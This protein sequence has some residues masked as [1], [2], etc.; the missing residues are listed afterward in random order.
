MEQIPSRNRPPKGVKLQ[1]QPLG[2]CVPAKPA[3]PP[4]AASRAGAPAPGN[5]R[6]APGLAAVPGVHPT[7]TRPCGSNSPLRSMLA[8]GPPLR[9]RPRRTPFRASDSNSWAPAAANPSASRRGQARDPLVPGGPAPQGH[10]EPE[11]RAEGTGA[12]QQ[13]R[14]CPAAPCALKPWGERFAPRSRRPGSAAPSTL[15]AIL[16][17]KAA[18]R[19]RPPPPRP[20]GPPPPR[21]LQKG[22]RTHRRAPGKAPGARLQ[23]RAIGG[24]GRLPSSSPPASP[25]SPP[26]SLPRSLAPSFSLRSP[27]PLTERLPYKIYES[28]LSSPCRAQSYSQGSGAQQRGAASQGVLAAPAPG[29]NPRPA[30]VQVPAPVPGRVVGPLESPSRAPWASQS[31]NPQPNP[32]PLALRGWRSP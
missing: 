10:G 18:P 13:P 2:R 4:G 5:S 27:P 20:L 14:R 26:P 11:P 24:A 12:H 22:A 31:S 15:Q 19:P 29:D 23:D 17:G 30:S 21:L 6:A 32:R 16:R 9:G 3:S 28:A 8:A 25:T 7:P 1:Q